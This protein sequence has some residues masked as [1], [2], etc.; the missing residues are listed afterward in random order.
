MPQ[1]SLWQSDDSLCAVPRPCSRMIRA[2][3]T[4]DSPPHQEVH[5]KIA[6]FFKNCRIPCF[7]EVS[8]SLGWMKG[9]A[10]DAAGPAELHA[11]YRRVCSSFV[12]Q[13]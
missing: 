6:D 11:Q 5:K 7:N 9:L 8:R 13:T 12:R 3:R 4:V 10:K 2:S 1:P